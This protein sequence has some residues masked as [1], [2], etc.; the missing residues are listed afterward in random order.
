[1]MM[2]IIARLPA[3]NSKKN[4]NVNNNKNINISYDIYDICSPI[5]RAEAR[6]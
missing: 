3:G 5:A 4:D 1:M 2:F 6:A